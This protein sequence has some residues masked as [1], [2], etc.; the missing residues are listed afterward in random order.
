[1]LITFQALF[2]L[3]LK[4]L[5]ILQLLTDPWQTVVLPIYLKLWSS[6][7]N[8]KKLHVSFRESWLGST[9]PRSNGLWDLLTGKNSCQSTAWAFPLTAYPWGWVLSFPWSWDFFTYH[10]LPG[11]Q[12]WNF[13]VYTRDK[14]L[15]LNSLT[16]PSDPSLYFPQQVPP[17]LV[18]TTQQS[19]VA[20]KLPPNGLQHT[21]LRWSCRTGEP[22]QNQSNQCGCSPFLRTRSVKPDASDKRPLSLPEPSLLPGLFLNSNKNR[23]PLEHWSS[24]RLSSFVF[25]KRLECQVQRKC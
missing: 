15:P 21:S 17:Q 11:P 10:R 23:T 24:Q 6:F 13:Q 3:W 16:L 8:L 22:S 4:A 7:V 20:C 25:N 18:D 12:V 2:L 14:D 5:S 1:M 19:T 9:C